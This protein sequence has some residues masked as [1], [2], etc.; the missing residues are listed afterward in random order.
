MTQWSLVTQGNELGYV[1]RNRIGRIAQQ[2][3]SDVILNRVLDSRGA[4]IL[5]RKR[6]LEELA[7]DVTARPPLSHIADEPAFRNT[8]TNEGSTQK[9]RLSMGISFITPGR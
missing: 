7:W 5:A 4:D 2:T 9:E 6:T 8:F 3:V 1:R